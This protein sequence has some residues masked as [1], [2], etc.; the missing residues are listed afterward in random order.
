MKK[1]TGVDTQPNPKLSLKA[2]TYLSP[3]ALVRSLLMPGTR[4][5]HPIQGNGLYMATGTQ[6]VPALGRGGGSHS[7]V[8]GWVNPSSGISDQTEVRRD[9]SRV[10]EAASSP[11]LQGE[12]KGAGRGLPQTETQRYSPLP[13]STYLGDCPP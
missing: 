11:G 1:H 10:Q 8:W 3:G 12:T 6:M 7:P 4:E 2:I 13:Q 5:A 9:S